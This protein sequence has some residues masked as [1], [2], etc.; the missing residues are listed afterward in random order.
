MESPR[1]K[2]VCIVSLDRAR[3]SASAVSR[4]SPSGLHRDPPSGQGHPTRTPR[5]HPKTNTE[6][7]A[8][9]SHASS[10]GFLFRSPSPPRALSFSR[11]PKHEHMHLS[12]MYHVR[13]QSEPC[14]PIHACSAPSAKRVA[15][16][17]AS[18]QS[19]LRATVNCRVGSYRST[20]NWLRFFIHGSP[21]PA[22]RR[23]VSSR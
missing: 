12:C 6:H 22:V 2:T 4:T 3:A 23:T 10:E 14:P 19:E 21:R 13:H 16:K 8:R 1:K 5:R 15:T 7:S 18:T 20:G 9:R 11:A 17:C